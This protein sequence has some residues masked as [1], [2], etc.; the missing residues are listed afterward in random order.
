VTEVGWVSADEDSPAGLDKRN[1]RRKYRE[2]ERLLKQLDDLGENVA[3]I[4]GDVLH[5]VGESFE[6]RPGQG[7]LE[8]EP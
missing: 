8:I 1:I 3:D 5:I 7:V 4:Q 2:I 6:I